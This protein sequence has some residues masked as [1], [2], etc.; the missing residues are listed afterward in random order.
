MALQIKKN[1]NVYEISGSLNSSNTEV[2]KKHFKSIVEQS[3]LVMISLK[4]LSEIDSESVRM[5][6]RM[7]KTAMNKNRVIYLLGKSNEKV[8]NMFSEQRIQ[9]ILHKTILDV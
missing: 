5:L 9:F 6:H 3:K 2:F 7:Y 1:N 4:N 8:K